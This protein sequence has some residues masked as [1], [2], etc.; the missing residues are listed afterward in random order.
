MKIEIYRFT[1]VASIMVGVIAL[2]FFSDYGIVACDR[3]YSPKPHDMYADG[4]RYVVRIKD[5][6]SVFVWTKEVPCTDAEGFVTIKG[7]ASKC[8]CVYSHNEPFSVSRRDLDYDIVKLMPNSI[9]NDGL[10]HNRLE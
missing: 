10:R 3:K 1:R 7:I 6:S 4:Y 5:N 2:V 8:G 9:W